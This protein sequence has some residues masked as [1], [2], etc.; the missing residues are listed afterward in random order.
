MISFSID[1]SLTISPYIFEL[2]IWPRHW[3]ISKS[4]LA[5][6]AIR[7]LQIGPLCFAV[8]NSAKLKAHSEKAVPVTLD[9][10]YDI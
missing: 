8:T 3:V 7:A 4:V 5:D 10:L 1:I 9:E 2:S 6:G